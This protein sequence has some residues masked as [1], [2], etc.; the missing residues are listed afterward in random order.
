MQE[1]S[2]F[3]DANKFGRPDIFLRVRDKAFWIECKFQPLKNGIRD[4]HWNMAAWMDYDDSIFLQAMKY[5]TA[6]RSLVNDSFTGGHFVMTLVFKII[7]ENPASHMV[8][9]VV[10]LEPDIIDP[11][12]RGWFYSLF[13]IN[14]NSAPKQVGIE[15]YGTIEKMD[16]STLKSPNST[17]FTKLTA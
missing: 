16:T 14:E 8:N 12:Y 13:F 10:N 6:E 5:Y 2:I 11:A 3:D 1:Y 17:A 15:V 7:K 4:D 9:A